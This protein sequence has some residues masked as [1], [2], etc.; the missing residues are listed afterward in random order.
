MTLVSI[1][2]NLLDLAAQINQEHD[3]CEQAYRSGL[4]HARKAGNLLN[5][6]KAQVKSQFGH[7][8]WLPWLAENCRVAE[9]TAQAYMRID[10]E[11]ARLAESA[12]IAELSFR[13][14]L[15]LLSESDEPAI[16]E[17]EFVAEPVKTA[18][19]HKFGIGEAVQVINPESLY[20][21][22][23]IE[24]VDKIGDVLLCRTS[25]V[26]EFPFLPAELAPTPQPPNLPV[27]TTEITETTETAPLPTPSPAPSEVDTLK[28][29]LREVYEACGM[30]LPAA[31]ASRVA[32][33][34]A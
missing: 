32:E 23:T 14:A 5:Q 25:K 20:A 19:N 27:E 22:E 18:S 11:W 24:I 2:P 8:R 10:R 29:L 30:A 16:L 21:G 33:V 31:L 17:A 6:V 28:G 26:A 15:T 3:A 34:L 4:E 13:D 12:T 9:R 7:G 1:E